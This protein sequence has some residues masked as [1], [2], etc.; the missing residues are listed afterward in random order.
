[1]ADPPAN[2]GWRTGATETDLEGR[3][4]SPSFDLSPEF[5]AEAEAMNAPAATWREP[6]PAI[7]YMPTESEAAEA[8]LDGEAA[9]QLQALPIGDLLPQDR[10]EDRRVGLE[11]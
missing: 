1:M 3:V 9:A 10:S 2:R 5:I 4:N 11:L 8:Q 7:E 6:P